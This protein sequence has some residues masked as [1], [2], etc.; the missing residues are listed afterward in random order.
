MADAGPAPG[1]ASILE[2]ILADTRDEVERRQ[3]DVPFLEVVARAV[4]T[5]IPRDFH[6]ALASTSVSLIAEFKRAS[7]SKGDIYPDAMPAQ[8]AAAYEVGGARAM[9][10]LTNERYFRGSDEDLREVRG[11]VSLPILRKDF[12]VSAYQIHEARLIGADAVLL[13]VAA[14]E[15]G[16]L[17]EFMNVAREIGVAALTEV[18]SEAEIERAVAAGAEIIGINNR[19]LHT[20]ETSL[21]TTERLRRFVPPDSLVVSESGI[22]DRDDVQRLDRVRVDAVLVGES[23]MRA[24]ASA[25]GRAFDEA[26]AE[27]VRELLAS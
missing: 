11:A 22:A 3:S 17:H 1:R 18:H 19:N 10:V 2:R 12:T 14:L 24:A 25:R 15:D 26:L 16:E 23:L 13:I 27:Q 5:P 20:F 4:D 21:E 7:P 6:G 8:V 9:S